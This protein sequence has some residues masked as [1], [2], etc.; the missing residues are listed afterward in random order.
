MRMLISCRSCTFAD[1]SSRLQFTGRNIRALTMWT[2][3]MNVISNTVDRLRQRQLR[4]TK[5]A[6]HDCCL[7]ELLMG[8]M[9]EIPCVRQAGLLTGIELANYH[10]ELSGPLQNLCERLSWNFPLLCLIAV[11]WQIRN[12]SEERLFEFDSTKIIAETMWNDEQK[13]R[14]QWSI[15]IERH[16][17]GSFLKFWE[18]LR[19]CMR[20]GKGAREALIGDSSS[21]ESRGMPT[22]SAL[23]KGKQQVVTVHVRSVTIASDGEA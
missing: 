5:N 14:E 16:Y 18:D 15:Q 20:G 6:K 8:A 12:T 2:P 23:I 17:H 1:T 13:R 22:A 9:S 3:T 10:A 21:I 11:E 19:D 4:C 7:S